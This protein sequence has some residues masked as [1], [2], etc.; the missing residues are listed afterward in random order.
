[1]YRIGI[2]VGGTNTDAA[3]LDQAHNVISSTKYPTTEDIQ[4]GIEQAVRQV[5][6]GTNID[7]R[8]I[9][10][11]MLG[12]TQ[13]TNAIVERKKLSKVGLLRLAYPA[14]ESVTPYTGWPEDMT[15]AIEGRYQ[16]LHGGFEYDGRVLSEINEEE[17]KGVLKEWAG[18]IESLAIVGVFSSLRNDQEYQVAQWAREVLGE[19]F[20]VSCSI[21][22]GS[23]SL[24][25]RENATILNAALDKVIRI[26]TMGFEETLKK[27]NITGAKVFLCQNDGTLM[28]L[29]YAKQFP[30]LTIASGPTNSIRG[31]S[32]L[33]GKKE[34]IVL[35]VGGTTSDLGVLAEGFPRESSFAVNIGDIRTNFRMPDILSIGLGGGSI[36]HEKDGEIIVGPDSVGYNI[37]SEAKVFGG[38]TLTATDI[39]V[40]VGATDIGD[41]TLVEDIP[42]AFAEKVMQKIQTMIEIEVDKMKTSAEDV[43][44]ILVGGGAVVVPQTLKGVA[45]IYNDENAGVANAI[46]ASIAQISGQFE[47]IYIYSQTP[48]AESMQDAQENAAKQAELAGAEKGSTELVEIEETPLAYHPENATRIKAKVVGDMKGLVP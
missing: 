48:R 14:T 21:D 30:V 26:T 3:I 41:P 23:I 29:E 22:I 42:L 25:E 44:L 4:T 11:A 45:H 31:A 24:L 17:V 8:N 36:V 5:L 12:T 46:G 34:A 16:I 37:T 40:R 19:D 28:S 35:D 13:C 2:D 43:D 6:A 1:M 18:K 15:E 47:K 7:P 9:S 33:A 20:P 32:F 27:E 38:S 39:A 10:Q